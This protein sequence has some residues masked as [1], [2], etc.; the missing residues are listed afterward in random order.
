MKKSLHV[1]LT[2]LLSLHYIFS[3]AQADNPYHMN[4]NAYQ[5]N[6]NCYTLTQDLVNQ[7]GSVWNKNKID[8]TQPF[9]FK[10]NVYLGCND[11]PGADGIVFVLQPISTSVGTSGQG[12]GFEGVSPSIGIAIDTWQNI[13]FNDPYYDHIGIYKNGDLNNTAP[14]PNRLAGPVTALAGSDNIEDCQWHTFRITWDATSHLLSAQMDGVDRVQAVVDLVKDIFGANPQVFWGFSGATGGGTNWQR[15][16]TSLNPGFNLDDDQKTCYPTPILFKDSSTSFGSIVKW[17]WDFGDGSSDFT[18]SPPPHVYPEPGIYEVKLNILGNNGCVSDTFRKQIIVGSKPVAGFGYIPFPACAGAPVFFTDSSS[19]Q[20]GNINEWVWNINNGQQIIHNAGPGLEQIFPVSSQTISLTVTT[21]QGCISETTEHT[22]GVF[23]K[24]TPDMTLTDGCFREPVP[25]FAGNAD[26]SVNIQQWYWLP[27]D[28]SIDSTAS[29]THIYPK[30]GQYQVGLFATGNG[31]CHSDTLTQVIKI[32]ETNAYAGRDT[33][34]TIGQPLQL[35]GTGGEMYSWQPATGLNN[36]DIADP[37][38]ILDQDM[39]YVLKAY[40]ALG[41]ATF[42]TIRI[43]AY[44][45]P[46]IYMPSAFTPNHDGINDRFRP[47]AVGITEI[48]FFCIYNRYGQLLFSTANATEGWD[49]NFQGKA[50]PMGTYVWM[51]KGR[52]YNGIIHS[53]KGTVTLIR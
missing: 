21:Q 7:S 49:G 44:K 26:P 34:M 10:F 41:C 35:H 30:G 3:A 42:D 4:G 28:G 2:F 20:F 5:E 39:N 33:V 29:V 14:A 53:E 13:D 46:A 45:G 43:K 25:F 27:G 31:G 8:L 24:P 6:C 19:V 52:D 38:A 22:F 18:Q 50:Q 15:F 12:L 23:P 17:F 16:C 9:D 40:T 37:V 1:L 36:P 51:V 32:Y 48:S 47:V 11:S